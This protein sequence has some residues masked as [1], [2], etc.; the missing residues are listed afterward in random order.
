M[1][2]IDYLQIMRDDLLEIAQRHGVT[3][4]RVFGSVARGDD[5]VGSDIDLLV[6][7]GATVSPWFPAGLILELQDLLGRPVE[8]VTESGLN[9]LLREQV[10]LE[11]V[12]L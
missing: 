3:S 4:V 8:I 12:S 6:T 2:T 1:T 7:T 10:F 9:P 11:A 5:S